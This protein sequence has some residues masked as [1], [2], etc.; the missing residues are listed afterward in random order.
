MLRSCPYCSRIHD[1]R[2]KCGPMVTAIRRRQ[3]RQGT[4]ADRF[5]R[6]NAWTEKSI[7]IR[8]RD[9][10]MCLC[11][12]AQ[13]VGTVEQIQTEGLSVHHIV[14]IEEDYSKRLDDDNLM[15]VCTVH[16]EMCEANKIT[17]DM[18]R[19]LVEDST[20]EYESRITTLA[21]VL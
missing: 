18:Q 12:K 14:P 9:H 5:R 1:T 19:K 10:Y 20:K 2:I 4:D 13:L 8:E 17:R 7:H 16:H 11:C 6:T 3:N 15:T 21:I